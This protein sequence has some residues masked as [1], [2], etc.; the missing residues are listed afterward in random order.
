LSS[1]KCCSRRSTARFCAV[2]RLAEELVGA[3]VALEDDPAVVPVEL[4]RLRA[5]KEVLR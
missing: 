5:I 1:F 4:E 3:G 2:E